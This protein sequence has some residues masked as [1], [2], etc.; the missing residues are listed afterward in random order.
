MI[1]KSTAENV[2]KQACNTGAEFAEIFIEE[3]IKNS[4]SLINGDV[5]RAVSGVDFGFGL[6]IIKGEKVLYTYT[7]N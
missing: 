1:D 7:N 5:Y 3:N 4:I 6:R 2:L